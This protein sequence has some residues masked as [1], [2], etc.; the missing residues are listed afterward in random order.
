MDYY[1]ILEI[2]SDA[3]EREIKRAYHRLARDLHPD[4][5]SSPEEAKTLQ[6]RFAQ[7][8]AAY[9]TLKTEDKRGDYDRTRPKKTATDPTPT[10]AR[11]F[12][13]SPSSTQKIMQ[14]GRS[15]PKG[16]A[17]PSQPRQHLGLTP[18]K[19]AIAQKAYARGMQHFKDNNFSKAIDFFDA[20]IQNNETEAGYHAKLSLSRIHAHKSATRAIDAGQK[21]IELDPY[22]MDYKFNLAMIFETIGSKSNAQ[23]IYDEILRWESDNVRAK[24]ALQALKKG[25]ASGL[26]FSNGPSSSATKKTP[27]FLDQLKKLFN[28]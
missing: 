17:K 22:N 24:S 18:E 20:A 5:A 8:S 15:V 27:S 13:Q 9:N 4:K 2:P 19:I 11:K 14:A 25:K 6:D 10:P 3:D 21:A 16:A 23:K 7:V 26:S 12:T 1:E 28:R